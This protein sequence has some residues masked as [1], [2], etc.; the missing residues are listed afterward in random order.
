MPLQR[1]AY[2]EMQRYIVFFNDYPQNNL[3]LYIIQCLYDIKGRSPVIFVV[4]RIFVQKSRVSGD[5]FQFAK[6]KDIRATLLNNLL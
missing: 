3:L 4:M 1:I 2:F 5:I 6:I